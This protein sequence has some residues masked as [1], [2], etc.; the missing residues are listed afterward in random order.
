MLNQQIFAAGYF[1]EIPTSDSGNS[2]VDSSARPFVLTPLQ[3]FS[4][5]IKQLSLHR[6]INS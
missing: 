3:E 2:S 6:A 1:P 4:I 5:I